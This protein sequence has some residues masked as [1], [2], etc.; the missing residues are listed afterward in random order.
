MSP[1]Q[2]TTSPSREVLQSAG[3]ISKK[4]ADEKAWAEYNSYN[5]QRRHLKE[6]EGER[7]SI[8][9]LRSISKQNSS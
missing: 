3:Q 5:D 6:T 7:L 1:S 8:E 4:A 9:V 2:K